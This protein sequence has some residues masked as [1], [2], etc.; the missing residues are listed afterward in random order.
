MS[1]KKTQAHNARASKFDQN[2][3]GDQ[4]EYADTLGEA[5]EREADVAA[6]IAASQRKNANISGVQGMK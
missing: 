1:E 4:L 5:D 3:F 2:I 6:K